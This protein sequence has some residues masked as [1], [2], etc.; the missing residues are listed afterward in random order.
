[1]VGLPK[2]GLEKERAE[3]AGL[4]KHIGPGRAPNSARRLAGLLGGPGR[5]R[6]WPERACPIRHWIS[7]KLIPILARTPPHSALTSPS[8]PSAIPFSKLCQR[9]QTQKPSVHPSA[10]PPRSTGGSSSSRNPLPMGRE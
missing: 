3:P 6:N 2:A 10:K 1:M 9:D 4:R 5:A 8:N 7:T